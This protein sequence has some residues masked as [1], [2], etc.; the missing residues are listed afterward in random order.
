MGGAESA[1]VNEV[2]VPARR[3][4]HVAI[5]EVFRQTESNS[6]DIFLS[7]ESEKN[8]FG[9]AEKDHEIWR[10]KRESQEGERKGDDETI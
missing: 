4:I 5:C 10:R 8:L 9:T 6:T 2:A 3:G 1:G 7:A